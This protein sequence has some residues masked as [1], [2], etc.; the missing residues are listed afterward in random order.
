[1]LVIAVGLFFLRDNIAKFINNAAIQIAG[2]ES[3]G[4]NEYGFYFDKIYW[5]EEEN[6][7]VVYHEDGSLDMVDKNGN[8]LMQIAPSGSY[9]YEQGVAVGQPDGMGGNYMD[10]S[11]SSDGKQSY[12]GRYTLLE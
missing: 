9:V 11:F 8:V 1:M 3:D 7:G 4:K 12:S 5:S 2:E 10:V 6:H